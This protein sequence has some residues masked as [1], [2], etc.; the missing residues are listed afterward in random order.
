MSELSK[1]LRSELTQS[2]MAD[3]L[4]LSR[5]IAEHEALVA[6]GA[7]ADEIEQLENKIRELQPVRQGL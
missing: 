4:G 7:A 3:K 1:W 2:Q 6:Y 5:T